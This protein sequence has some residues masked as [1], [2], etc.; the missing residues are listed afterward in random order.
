MVAAVFSEMPEVACGA[1]AEVKPLPST[2]GSTQPAK[3]VRK[4]INYLLFFPSVWVPSSRAV[5]TLVVVAAAVVAVAAAAAAA[6]GPFGKQGCCC[7]L[8]PSHHSF[9]ILLPV[10][11]LHRDRGTRCL[12]ACH[13]SCV[14]DLLRRLWGQ[15]SLP[16]HHEGWG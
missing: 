15:S 7:C 12:A 1:Q 2:P 4:T 11:Q 5:V 3:L 10:S 8:F 9:S 13:W 14:T 6:T 16:A